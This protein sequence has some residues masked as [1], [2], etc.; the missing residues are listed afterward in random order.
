MRKPLDQMSF[1]ELA[2]SHDQYE[3]I[4]KEL[5]DMLSDVKEALCLDSDKEAEYMLTLR[6][7]AIELL[8]RV[9]PLLIYHG[10]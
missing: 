2:K 4:A 10:T 9:E 6:G 8:A 3:D 5:F 1:I 7:Q